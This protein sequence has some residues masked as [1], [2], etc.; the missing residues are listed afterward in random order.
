MLIFVDNYKLNT[1][2]SCFNRCKALKDS[3]FPDVLFYLLNMSTILKKY[4][5][6]LNTQ[7][8][9]NKIKNLKIKSGNDYCNSI[10]FDE[11]D[12]KKTVFIK[13]WKLW[14]KCYLYQ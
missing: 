2:A 13:K 11:G 8:A 9:K 7:I 4:I 14:I 1:K 6:E 10:Y 3:K 12:M 5:H